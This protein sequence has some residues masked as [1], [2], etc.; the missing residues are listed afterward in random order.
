MRIVVLLAIN[1]SFSFNFRRIRS[2]TSAALRQTRAWQN[3]TKLLTTD[4]PGTSCA[5][6]ELL[7]NPAA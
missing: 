4:P 6:K 3:H 5:R 7:I 2:A 1:I